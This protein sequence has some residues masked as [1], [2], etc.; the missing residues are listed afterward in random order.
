M[1]NLIQSRRNQERVNHNGREGTQR[2]KIKNSAHSGTLCRKYFFIMFLIITVFATSCDLQT[3]S[4]YI[5]VT[6]TFQPGHPSLSEITPTPL[7]ARTT[8]FPGQLVDYTAQSGDTLPA[9]ANRF[10][11]TVAEIMQANTQIPND[12]TTMPPGM[13]MQIPIYYSALWSSPF[14]II[15]DHA[16]VNSPTG[17]GFNTA[18]F[19]ATQTGWLKDYRVYA[20]GEWRS[21][22][23]MVDYVATNYSINP[24]LLLAIL[25]YQSG[26]LTQ[27]EIPVKKNMLGFKQLFYEAPYLQ[28]VIAANEL[29][30]GY[31]GWRAGSLLE[32]KEVDSFLIRPDPWQNAASASIQYY[33][34]RIFSGDE[35]TVATGPEGLFLTYKNF[36]GDPWTDSFT[37][38]PGSLQQPKLRLPFP[39]N[40]IWTFTGGPHTGWGTGKPF[41]ALDFAPPSEKSGCVPAKAEN[42]ATAMANGL[43]VRSNV[44][45]GLALDLDKDGDE[46]TGWVIYYL[47]LSANKL[48]PLGAE[49]NAGDFIGYPSCEGGERS[50]GTHIHIARKYNGEWMLAD[51]AT[52]FNLDGWIAYNGSRDYLGILIKGSA[53]VTACTC[54][55]ANSSISSG[56][57]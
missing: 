52:P 37:L 42:Y 5:A 44:T 9:L 40:Q 25:E 23:E 27:S 8:Y 47:H 6:P 16:F 33:Y 34:S 35:Y 3:S 14:K 39:D 48:A 10:N 15:P 29:N 11:T 53:L 31:Y 4:A 26:A 36:F 28:L 43:V 7:P 45:N 49:I 46:R 1:N 57:P 22:A 19:V 54:S 24:R 30:N 12:A 18:A 17:I 41:S 32:F 21:G 51:S 2:E 38:I 56:P 20:S 55:N 50:T 13:P